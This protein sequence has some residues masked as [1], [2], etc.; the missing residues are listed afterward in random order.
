MSLDYAM[1]AAGTAYDKARFLREENL[2]VS[3]R[4]FNDVAQIAID[5]MQGRLDAGM[6]KSVYNSYIAATNRYLIPFFLQA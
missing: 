6:G 5:E 1:Q 2:P 4:R 3:S